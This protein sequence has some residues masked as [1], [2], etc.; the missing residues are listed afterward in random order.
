ML[1]QYRVRLNGAGRLVSNQNIP[2]AAKE[3]FKDRL[4]AMGD[5]LKQVQSLDEYGGHHLAAIAR[6]LK[7]APVPETETM[8][9]EQP[10]PCE[11]IVWCWATQSLLGQDP[12]EG[13]G[14]LRPGPTVYGHRLQYVYPNDKDMCRADR[15]QV[16]VT[17][18]LLD[19]STRQA[20]RFDT[21]MDNAASGCQ[22]LFHAITELGGIEQVQEAVFAFLAYSEARPPLTDDM[23]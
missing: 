23:F 16:M 3:Q 15:E 4:E 19:V 2:P 10:S 9:L 1:G 20:Y 5:A 14:C 7:E 18:W 8:V 6:T 21:T 11:D 13:M 17:G 12:L 22:E